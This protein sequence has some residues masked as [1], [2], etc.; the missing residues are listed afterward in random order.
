MK[1][2]EPFVTHVNLNFVRSVL[3]IKKGI[4]VR[5]KILVIVNKVSYVTFFGFFIIIKERNKKCGVNL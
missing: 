3:F 1:V 2:L 4:F 5:N